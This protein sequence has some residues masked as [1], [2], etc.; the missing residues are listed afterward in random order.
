MA[1]EETVSGTVTYLNRS[2]LPSGAV[3]NAGQGA[4]L[5]LWSIHRKS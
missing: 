2:V 1:E 5:L 4:V 3:L